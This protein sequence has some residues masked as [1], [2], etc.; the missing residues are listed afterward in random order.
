MLAESG[1]PLRSVMY[2]VGHSTIDAAF[3]YQHRAA[4][5]NQ[6]EADALA[7]RMDAHRLNN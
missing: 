2:R 3:V 6:A 1:M 4:D 7:T 5:R